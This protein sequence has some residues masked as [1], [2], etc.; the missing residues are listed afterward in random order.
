MT[1][2]DSFFQ[3]L[4]DAIIRSS[5][6]SINGQT[7]REN[8]ANHMLAE[9]PSYPEIND[10]IS[11]TNYIRQA[12]APLDVFLIQNVANI[13]G[14]DIN[15]RTAGEIIAVRGTGPN[16]LPIDLIFSDTGF[17]VSNLLPVDDDSQIPLNQVASYAIDT[18][19]ASM[20]RALLDIGI[21]NI[22]YVDEEGDTWLHIAALYGAAEIAAVLCDD[23]VSREK[24]NLNYQTALDIAR[25]Q[26]HDTTAYILNYMAQDIF[27]P[28]ET[29]NNTACAIDNIP[30]QSIFD[31]FIDWDY[32]NL[33]AS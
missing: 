12:A 8:I 10:I 25:E 17:T 1:V 21:I 15:I 20:F 5:N 29:S 3:S 2:S 32:L 14:L 22:N 26:N 7:I 18:D 23:Y 6:L 13:L 28:Q 4:A 9:W 16:L 27:V 30:E 11:Y 33:Y 19:N 31:I 24:V